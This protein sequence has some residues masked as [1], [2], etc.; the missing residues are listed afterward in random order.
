MCGTDFS[1]IAKF[2]PKR[3]RRQI[4]NKYKKEEKD[5]EERVED[6]LRNP[7]KMDVEKFRR[8]AGLS[9]PATKGGPPPPVQAPSISDI[10]LDEEETPISPPKRDVNGKDEV[11]ESSDEE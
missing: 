10:G 8:L 5:N 3:T 7:L 6:A 1:L 11:F 2:F 4:R 9:K